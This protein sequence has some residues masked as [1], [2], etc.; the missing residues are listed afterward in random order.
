MKKTS[1]HKLVLDRATIRRLDGAELLTAAG[2]D[3]VRSIDICPTIELSVCKCRTHKP[4]C[5]VPPGID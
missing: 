2:G 4:G 1:P 5:T 3:K